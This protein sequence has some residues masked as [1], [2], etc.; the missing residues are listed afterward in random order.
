M[1][2]DDGMRDPNASRLQDGKNHSSWQDIR[3]MP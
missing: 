2:G 1:L 3:I